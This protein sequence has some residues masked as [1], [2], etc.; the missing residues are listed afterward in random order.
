MLYLNKNT[1]N[2]Y[3][4]TQTQAVTGDIVKLDGW[5]QIQEQVVGWANLQ[6]MPGKRQPDGSVKVYYLHTGVV[7]DETLNCVDKVSG[8]RSAKLTSY[9]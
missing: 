9:R 8:I 1:H 5:Y 7:R 2:V 6:F 4:S 3:V